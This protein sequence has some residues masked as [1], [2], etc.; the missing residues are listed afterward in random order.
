MPSNSIHLHSQHV[1]AIV[2]ES[3]GMMQPWTQQD[4]PSVD[5]TDSLAEPGRR[6]RK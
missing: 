3:L 1:P 5:D 6:L 4:G 2:N